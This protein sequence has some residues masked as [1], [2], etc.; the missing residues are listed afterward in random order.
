MKSLLLNSTLLILISITAC[1]GAEDFHEEPENPFSRQKRPLDTADELSF[2]LS[3][4]GE[5][6]EGIGALQRQMSIPNGG[7]N[8]SQLL[9]GDPIGTSG[10][11]DEFPDHKSKKARE[12]LGAASSTGATVSTKDGIAPTLPLSDDQGGATLEKVTSV[13]VDPKA[14]A[15]VS[16]RKPKSSKKKK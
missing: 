2:L 9:W 13:E 3:H 4:A 7:Y 16:L 15:P 11:D 12:A 14:A 6:A 1:H 5:G 8:F 10:L